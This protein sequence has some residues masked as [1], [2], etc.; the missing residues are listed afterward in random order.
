[1]RFKSH[2]LL[3][4]VFFPLV[5]NTWACPSLTAARSWYFDG[6]QEKAIKALHC[7]K[8]S[9]PDDL[10]VRRFLSDIDW[11]HGRVEGSIEEAQRAEELNPWTI[12]PDLAIHLAERTRPF[13][14]TLSADDV[15]GEG[16][17]GAD[18]VS[19]L[20]Y[21]FSGR[22][23]GRIGFSRLS[24]TFADS[25]SLTDRVFQVGY[26]RVQGERSYLDSEVSYSPDHGF[27]PEYSLG[28]EPHYVLHDDS[29]VSLLLK[30]LHYVNSG[31]EQEV[32]LLAPGWR[33]TYGRWTLNGSVN[34][35]LTE[36]ILPSALAGVIYPVL[37]KTELHFAT[38]GGRALEG[39]NL[40]DTFY[41]LGGGLT[42]FLR[43]E[44]SVTLDGSIYRGDLYSE[45]R[46]GLGADWFF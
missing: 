8:E 2:I 22:D 3:W 23:H 31:A 11:W 16:R 46:I 4:A 42:R 1:M 13:R 28:A 26:V 39:P 10:D 37:P 43:P 40:P 15:W 14:L 25:N 27:S 5:S 44:L 19:S 30:F 20:D 12:D 45:N 35:L 41:S 36:G 33:K 7:L 34:I 9:Y 38:S 18:V 17:N 21:R 32:L 29:D 24:R 6:Q